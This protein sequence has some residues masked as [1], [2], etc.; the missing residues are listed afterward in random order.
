MAYQT[1]RTHTRPNTDEPFFF[2]T[3][4]IRDYFK[5]T[6]DQTGKR[7]SYTVTKS[8]DDL[9]QIVTSIWVD[10]AAFNEYLSDPVIMANDAE[11]VKYNTE[12]GIVSVWTNSEVL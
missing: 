6:Y 11:L 10:E 4:Q 8:P 3:E 12:F 7:T 9:Q 2:F 5:N 1:I